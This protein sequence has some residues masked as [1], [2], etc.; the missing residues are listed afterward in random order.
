M[1]C[2]IILLDRRG[3]CTLS[4]FSKRYDGYTRHFTT[5][6]RNFDEDMAKKSQS[7]YFANWEVVSTLPRS[8]GKDVSF[9]TLPYKPKLDIN[10]KN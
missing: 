5:A 7:S 4:E 2:C 9:K 3:Y 1:L 6:E 8:H 10:Q